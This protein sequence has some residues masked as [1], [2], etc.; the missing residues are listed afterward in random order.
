MKNL[1]NFFIVAVMSAVL[2]SEFQPS[3]T[4]AV[5]IIGGVIKARHIAE[6]SDEKYPRDECPVCEGNGW[7][8]SGDGIEKVDC[9]YCEPVKKS[10]TLD[11]RYEDL[12]LV[13]VEPKTFILRRN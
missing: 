6:A 13:P 10:P 9:G 5:S 8:I 12:P 4:S 11:E 2:L 3:S 1:S 7:Y